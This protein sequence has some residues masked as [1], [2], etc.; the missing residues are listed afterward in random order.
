MVHECANMGCFVAVRDVLVRAVDVWN[1][2]D[3]IERHDRP[4][5]RSVPF[6]HVESHYT[7]H[8][9]TDDAHRHGDVHRPDLAHG[10]FRMLV[11]SPPS[12]RVTQRQESHIH[13]VL[14]AHG[15]H[16]RPHVRCI[17]PKSTNEHDDMSTE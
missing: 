2:I 9:E 4:H 10:P 14:I 11:Q 1:N 16:K 5:H 12:T 3:R 7:A 6:C 8:G 13:A 17:T 15:T